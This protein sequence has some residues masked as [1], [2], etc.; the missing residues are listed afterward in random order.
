MPACGPCRFGEGVDRLCPPALWLALSASARLASSTNNKK[1]I[2]TTV[3]ACGGASVPAS[4]RASEWL[5]MLT[6]RNMNQ[7]RSP[8]EFRIPWGRPVWCGR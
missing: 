1:R 6:F 5:G 2:L 4:A 7:P 3:C 8:L